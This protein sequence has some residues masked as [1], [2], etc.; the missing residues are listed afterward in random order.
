MYMA[1]SSLITSRS[2]SISTGSKV[3]CKNMSAS[4]SSNPRKFAV[5]RPGI[6]AG[7]LLA[8]EGVEVTADALDRLRNFPRRP[9]PGPLEQQVLDEMGHAVQRRRF[10]AAAHARP[11]SRR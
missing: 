8:G 2:L 10:M 3:E 4:T 1:N 11:K 5:A 6:K 9:F 7:L